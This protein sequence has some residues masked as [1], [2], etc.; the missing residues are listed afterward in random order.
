MAAMAAQLVPCSP[1]VPPSIH[2]GH[3]EGEAEQGTRSKLAHDS[4]CVPRTRAGPWL[5]PARPISAPLELQLPQDTAA[6]PFPGSKGREQMP[7]PAPGSRGQEQLR[8]SA[9]EPNTGG[10]KKQKSCV[11]GELRGRDV[12]RSS[13]IHPRLE[14]TACHGLA[15][16]PRELLARYYGEKTQQ[17][18]TARA[19]TAQPSWKGLTGRNGSGGGLCFGAVS[20][21]GALWRRLWHGRSG[22]V[23]DAEFGDRS[24]GPCCK[25]STFPSPGKHLPHQGG[26]LQGMTCSCFPQ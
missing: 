4:L 10:K 7:A 24:L 16:L 15:S 20:C 2:R 17:S 14:L 21:L 9:T 8:S 23:F 5:L 11:W 12:P 25:L 3:R 6:K 26:K 13:C 18:T 1:S 19:E 22:D